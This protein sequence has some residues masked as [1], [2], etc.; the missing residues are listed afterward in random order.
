M[1]DLLPAER[2]KLAGQDNSTACG[3][4]DLFDAAPERVAGLQR[5]K[6]RFAVTLYDTHDVVEI[7][8]NA[9]C[10]PADSLH[11]LTESHFFFKALSITNVLIDAIRA[12]ADPVYR[13]RYA[14]DFRVDDR[15]IFSAPARR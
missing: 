2:Q 13:E 1:R 7:V 8:R 11:F 15:S 4:V 12:C 10:Q 14:V 3:F 5:L 9:T 6:Q